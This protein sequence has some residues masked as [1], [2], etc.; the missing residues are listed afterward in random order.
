MV[1]TVYTPFRSSGAKQTSRRAGLPDRLRNLGTDVRSLVNRKE[2]MGA[3]LPEA[4]L[5]EVRFGWRT[6]AEST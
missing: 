3:H 4:D 1:T 6:L 2:P 5:R